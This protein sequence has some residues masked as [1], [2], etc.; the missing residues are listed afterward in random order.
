MFR[1]L[2][3]F[4]SF[5]RQFS[6]SRRSLLKYDGPII[7]QRVRFRRPIFTAKYAFHNLSLP[8]D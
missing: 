5:S 1:T 2:R 6:H 4:S 3:P 8:L 7:V